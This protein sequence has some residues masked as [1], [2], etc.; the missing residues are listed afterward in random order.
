MS[1]IRDAAK[2]YS[3]FMSGIEHTIER[4]IDDTGI[5]YLPV[6]HEILKAIFRNIFWIL[7]L[8]FIYQYYQVQKKIA[9]EGSH[10]PT[11]GRRNH[12]SPASKP[13]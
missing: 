3:T 8:S 10:C 9:L 12:L 11:C 4:Y 2:Q 5:W 13:E 6:I 7:L 1:S